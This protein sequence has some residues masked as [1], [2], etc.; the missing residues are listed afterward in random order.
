M[1]RVP[2][3]G[4]GSCWFH[5]IVRGFSRC[6]I[7]KQVIDA[8]TK[9]KQ[10]IDRGQFIQGL[11]NELADKLAMPINPDDP[12]SKTYYQCL[13]RGNLEDFSKGYPNSSM[14][15]MQKELRSGNA[16]DNIYHEYVSNC[17]NRDIYLLDMNTQDVYIMGDDMDL[18]YK[19]RGSVVI[20]VTPGHYDLV[21]VISSETNHVNSHFTLIV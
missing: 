5:S 4:D 15:F 14:E 2:V 19:G 3:I 6:Y 16:V 8:T 17:L 1:V 9:E 21:G 20:L 10:P 7:E 11:R 18:Y 13:S 12:K